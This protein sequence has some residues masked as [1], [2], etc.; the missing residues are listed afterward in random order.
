MVPF[1]LLIGASNA[2]L[3]TKLS[4][5]S[6]RL[7]KPEH[8]PKPSS[9]TE[10]F[11]T[12][13]ASVS[14]DQV[15]A[16]ASLIAEAPPR[17]VAS[18]S[19][20]RIDALDW[21]KGA[22]ILFMVAYHAINYS[23]FRPLAFQYMAFLPP[24]FILITGFLV[25]QVYA[26]KYNLR[27]WAP[28]TRLAT[29][30]V[31]LFLIFLL[32]N[33]VHCLLLERSISEGLW[34]FE[35]R[36]PA[37]FLSGNGRNGIFEIL[38]PIAYFLFLALLLL[39]VRSRSKAATVACGIAAFVLCVAL[40]RKG[41]SFKNLTLVSAGVIGMVL[42]LFRMALIVSFARKWV[43]VVCLYA[44]YRLCCALVGDTYPVEM[45]GATVSVL[46]IFTC[47]MGMQ[48]GSWAGQQ[49]VTLGRYSLF[50]YL[51]QIALLQG[52]VKLAGGKPNHWHGVFVTGVLTTGLLF[53]SVAALQWCRR[54][55]R[56]AD[57]LY[58]Y[59]FC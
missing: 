26:A 46:L 25:G 3:E 43:G 11:L 8:S 1:G 23:A 38:L 33:I 56:F 52:I 7:Q 42:G 41:I 50:A 54:R 57:S 16:P 51:V 32:L 2:R 18:G 20:Q 4:R 39:W 12:P 6:G 15:A 13:L 19:A 24:S 30:G 10:R 37:I 53:F 21:T 47:A 14:C 27:T 31:K 9:Q 44:L 28:Y 49:M 36:A 40:G 34:E 35:D 48:R 59:V 17:I 58:L 29:R 5:R 45:F 55:A 22:L